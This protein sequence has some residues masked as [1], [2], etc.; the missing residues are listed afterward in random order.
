M[1]VLVYCNFDSYS[2][3]SSKQLFKVIIVLKMDGGGDV[4]RTDVEK[5]FLCHIYLIKLR[6]FK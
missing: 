2:K 6:I 5:V 4:D 1:S 3:Q